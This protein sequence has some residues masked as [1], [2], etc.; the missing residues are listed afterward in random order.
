MNPFRG[1]PM[2]VEFKEDLIGRES[3]FRELHTKMRQRKHTMIMGVE[4]SGKSSFL[5]SFFSYDYRLSMA[6]DRK[7]LIYVTEYPTAL[8]SEGVYDYFAQMMEASVRIL[9]DCG[10]SQIKDN[11][12]QE[13]QEI[14]GKTTGQSRFVQTINTIAERGYRMVLVLDNFELFTSSQ[15]VTMEHH[16]L[17]R[18]LLHKIQYV[19]ATNYDFNKDSLPKGVRSSYL[20]QSFAKNEITMRGFT[21]EEAESYLLRELEGCEIQ[22]DKEMIAQLHAA[23]GGNPKLLYQA[24]YYAYELLERDPSA[25]FKGSSVAKDT[26]ADAKKTMEHWSIL[27]TPN[28]VKVLKELKQRGGILD[29]MDRSAAELLLQR[30]ILQEVYEV[31]AYGRN[32]KK[33]DAYAYNSKLYETFCT[34]VEEDGMTLMEKATLMNPLNAEGDEETG[35][36]QKTKSLEELL[37]ENL[38]KGAGSIIIKGDVIMAEGNKTTVHIERMSF[39]QNIGNPEQLRSIFTNLSNEMNGDSRF[40]VDKNAD[41][42]TL[43]LRYD[44]MANQVTRKFIPEKPT[45]EE[46]QTL[47]DRFEEIRSIR[48]EVTDEF[49]GQLSSECQFYLKIA[50]VVEDALRI[51][52]TVRLG[53]FSAQVV[54]YG[55]V[56][57][58]CLR[59]NMYL[60]F[61]TEQDLKDWDLY[62]H[63]VFAGSKKSF[64]GMSVNDTFI[65]NYIYMMRDKKS[66]LAQLCVNKHMQTEA[67]EIQ[68]AEKWKSW[69]SALGENVDAARNCRNT[70][71]HA[72]SRSEKDDLQVMCELL[73]GNNGIMARCNVADELYHKLTS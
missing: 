53:D 72:G 38:G 63:R 14:D 56:L 34:R 8:S 17:M 16:E 73:F 67:A 64:G 22:F 52:H 5:S 45:E 32:I 68:D 9:D 42:E 55:K 71:D 27:L 51:L 24:A 39:L 62:T 54:M 25:R 7:T 10:L 21:L 66:H 18:S 47:E 23:S 69:W 70:A 31:D 58:Q 1:T 30:G 35:V 3:E 28:Q 50:V 36:G 60:L 57:E 19:V 61:S 65:G 26:F 29:T 2:Q 48:P 20:L 59:D 37:A 46:L 4:G 41:A 11:I 15:A 33:S 6:R 49:L 13:L 44:E 40:F 12:C 43:D